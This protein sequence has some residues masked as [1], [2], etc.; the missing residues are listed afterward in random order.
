[1]PELHSVFSPVFPVDKDVDVSGDAEPLAQT[2]SVQVF[3]QLAEPVVFIQGFESPQPNDK[4]PSILRGSLVVRVLKATRLKSINLSFKGYSRTEWPEGIPPKRQD[5]VEINDIVNHTWPFYQAD[6]RISNAQVGRKSANSHGDHACLLHESGAS[7]YKPLSQTAL[8]RNKHQSISS[9]NGLSSLSL[10]SANASDARSLTD[11][12]SNTGRSLSPMSLLRRATSPAPKA[13]DHRSRTS[14]VT[15]SL[16]SDLLSG[17]FANAGENTSSAA[18]GDIHSINNGN[19]NVYSSGTGNENFVFQPGEYI[20]TFEQA[21]PS[22][23]PETV[24]ADFGYVEYQ[25]FVSI[26]RFGAFK[27]NITARLPVTLVRTQSDT[28]I[29]ETEP[30]AISRDWEDQLHYDIVIAS[31]DIILDAFLPLAFHFSPLD[32]VTL[33]RIRIYLTET[34]EYY[35]KNKKVHRMEPTKKFLLAEHDGPRL[36]GSSETGA[37]KAKNMGNLLLDESTGDL[38]NKNFEYQVFVPSILNNHQQL[39]PDTGLENIKANHWIKLCLRLSRMVDGKRKHY[40]ISIDSPIHV[41]HRLCSHANTLLPSYDSHISINEQALSA[42]AQFGNTS[43][44]SIY[45]SSNIFFPKEVLESPV[46]SPEVHP[47][48]LKVGSQSRNLSP[49]PRRHHDSKVDDSVML[50]SPPFRA[51]IYQPDQIQRE[52]TSPQAIPLSPVTSPHV[53]PLY[54][55]DAPP[56][57]DFDLNEMP[58]SKITRELPRNPPSYVDVMKADGIESDQNRK[59]RL[60]LKPPKIVF[61]RSEETLA[62]TRKSFDRSQRKSIEAGFN[63]RKLTGTDDDG[64]ITSGFIFQGVSQASANLPSAVLRS[65]PSNALS[66]NVELKKERR[67]SISGISPSTIRN[68]NT[69]FNDMSAILA[70][71]CENNEENQ[72]SRTASAYSDSSYERSA[73]SSIDSALLFANANN[74]EPL[75]HHTETRHN[76]STDNIAFQSRDS[77]TNYASSPIDSSVDI[78]ALYDRNSNGWHPLQANTEGTLSPVISPGYSA[79]VANSN[80]VFEDFKNALHQDDG[81][82]RDLHEDSVSTLRQSNESSS[83]RPT[84]PFQYDD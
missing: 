6:N 71:N 16:I 5:F 76:I 72:L 78:T 12:V 74:M 67:N 77:I 44:V 41:L 82:S 53:R 43:N 3:L 75:L 68:S 10:A 32:K 61:S 60:G 48:D 81:S 80:H 54:P 66:L 83:G 15:T 13:D 55:S 36:P 49:K 63:R 14:S 8:H 58:T 18:N 46:L 27:S 73:R 21:I 45:H 56:A 79:I 42:H 34:M 65:P 2:G 29:E 26:E 7:M 4:P 28:S 38:V 24:R 31:K 39:H 20:Y 11:A 35:C 19:D 22:S 51:N 47:L 33:H 69:P 37:L 1:M 57:F 52:L 30:I 25:L 40:E 70:N 64:D 17:T 62:E 84:S 9:L 59:S 23:Y 50:S